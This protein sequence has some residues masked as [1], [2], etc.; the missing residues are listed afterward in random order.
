MD[1][2]QLRACAHQVWTVAAAEMDRL[3]QSVDM[4][5]FTRVVELLAR[6]SG[7]V[8]TTGIG[9]SGIAARKLAHS[10]SCIEIPSF[11]LNPS[12]AVHGAMGSVQGGD[13]M[14]LVSKGGGTKE[15][16]Q[17][18]PSLNKKKVI[19]IAV[20]ENSESALGKG[21]DYLL[22]VQVEREA[23]PFDMLATTSILAVIAVFD[24]LCIALMQETGYTKEQFA[25]IHP[26]GAVGERLLQQEQED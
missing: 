7:R 19:T 8:V 1:D 26:A 16:V 21:C 14:F 2:L 5:A 20:T 23:D 6:H 15:L 25:V 17:L 22:Q 24:A 18:L 13:V 10:L 11:Y 3:K 12:D 4:E 9:T